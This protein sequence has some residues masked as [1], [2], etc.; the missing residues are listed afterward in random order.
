M[1]EEPTATD[2]KTGPK[3]GLA[4]VGG[5]AREPLMWLLLALPAAA[6]M[7]VLEYQHVHIPSLAM[8]AVACLGVIPLAGLMGRATENLAERM[9]PGIGGLLNATFGN[10]AELIIALMALSKGPQMFEFVKATITG[11]IIGNILL[12]LGASFIMG[13]VYHK[14]QKFN[15]TAASMGAT[16]LALAGVGLLIPS[17]HFYA[18]QFESPGHAGPAA[19]VANPH[20]LATL[21]EEIAVVLAITYGLS[22][23]FSLR[24]HRH[25]FGGDEA[26]EGAGTEAAATQHAATQEPVHHEPE[27]PQMTSII[28]LAVATIGIAWISEIL[29]G[30][31]EGAVHSL[32]M[33]KIFVGVIVVAVIGNAAEHSTAVLVAMKNK[34]DLAVN[35]AVGSSIQIALFVAPVIVLASLLMGHNPLMDLHFSSLEVLAVLISIGVLAMVSNDGESHW[36]EGVMLIAVYIMLGIA[37]AYW[38]EAPHATAAAVVHAG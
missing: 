36:M 9:G 21:S 8:F 14:R 24:T 20:T 15:A 25:L 35:I 16:L 6:V 13:G 2:S 19:A 18:L 29:V 32:G 37:F 12:V 23:F 31:I 33:S 5:L 34:M 38:P 11:S 17:F 27:W 28:V 22:L 4:I 10:A 30:S 26:E 7:E 3:S 1:G